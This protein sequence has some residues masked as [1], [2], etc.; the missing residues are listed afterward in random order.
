VPGNPAGVQQYPSAALGVQATVATLTNGDYPHLVAGLMQGSAAQFFSRPQE[1]ATWGT[2]PACVQP[3][4]RELAAGGA[5]PTS[6]AGGPTAPLGSAGRPS[7]SAAATELGGAG[8]PASA[9]I[10][11]A[12]TV[13]V[14]ALALAAVEAWTA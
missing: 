3:R 5:V 11:V 6:S 14:A 8:L 13:A 4:Y 10:G 2:D 1:L 12:A 9:W 7:A